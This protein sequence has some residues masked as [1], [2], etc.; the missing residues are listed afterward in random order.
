MCRYYLK[1]LL[2][3]GGDYQLVFVEYWLCFSHY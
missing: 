1:K 2:E 3:E